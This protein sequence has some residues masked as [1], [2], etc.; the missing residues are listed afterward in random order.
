MNRLRSATLLLALALLA[1]CA[2]LTPG[3]SVGPTLTGDPVLINEV[4]ASHTGTDDTE[5]IELFGTPGT[6]LAGLSLI[7]V[8]SDSGASQGSIDRRFDFKPFHQVGSNGF[9]L[10]GN[11]GGLASN[12]GAT[13][14]ASIFTNYLENSSLTVALVETASLSAAASPVVKSCAMRSR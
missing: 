7:V 5:F 4:L 8:E 3:D 13:P 9:F 1:A 14:D 2:Q 10:V 12:Y 11:C 6:S